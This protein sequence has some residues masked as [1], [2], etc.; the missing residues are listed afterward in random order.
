VHIIRGNIREAGYL[1]V[2]QAKSL[3]AWIWADW[4]PIRKVLTTGTECFATVTR[5]EIIC[6]C[7]EIA[8][9]G[10]FLSRLLRIGIAW[11][12]P[13]IRRADQNA[14][15]R[16][17]AADIND[18]VHVIFRPVS[19]LHIFSFVCQCCCSFMQDMVSV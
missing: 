10:K 8:Q 18:E 3:H 2:H 1:P 19:L 17:Q 4:T 5:T 15:I 16:I 6:I 7:R 13:P 11:S 14:P 12:W 9:D